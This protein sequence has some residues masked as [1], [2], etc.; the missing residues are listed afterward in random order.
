VLRKL[1]AFY[2]VKSEKLLKADEVIANP[3]AFITSVHI[4]A[5]KGDRWPV[6]GNR[7][8]EIE[9]ARDVKFFRRNP[10]GDGF[11]IYVSKE[12][13]PKAYEEFEASPSECVG[14]EP[15]AVWDPASIEQRLDDHM[16]GNSNRT[17]EFFLAS[18]RKRLALQ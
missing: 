2:A 10:S 7:H 16:N 5:L 12:R 15:L 13:P 9:L 4:S 11:L 14:L 17:M 6:I 1:M 3:V 18:L 8:L